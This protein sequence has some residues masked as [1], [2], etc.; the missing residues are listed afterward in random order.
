MGVIAPQGKHSFARPLAP[1]VT[2]LRHAL[3][4]WLAI[5]CLPA[6]KKIMFSVFCFWIAGA[7]PFFLLLTSSA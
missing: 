4:A 2:R 3:R 7:I 5:A 6:G 1:T